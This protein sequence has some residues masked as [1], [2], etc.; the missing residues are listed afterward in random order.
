M[1]N[2]SYEYQ[3]GMNWVAVAALILGVAPNLPGF[4]SALGL[5]EASTLAVTVYNWAWF[6]GF[7]ISSVTYLVGMK[8]MGGI[9]AGGSPITVESN[10]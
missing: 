5:F 4:L 1:R 10:E 6:V 3:R 8:M 2:G 9:A 7:A